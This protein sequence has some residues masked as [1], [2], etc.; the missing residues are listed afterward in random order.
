MKGGLA[1]LNYTQDDWIR[2][3]S[4][5]VLWAK[6]GLEHL[7]NITEPFEQ[8]G[9]KIGLTLITVSNERLL[10]EINPEHPYQLITQITSLRSEVWQFR[11]HLAYLDMKYKETLSRKGSNKY[12]SYKEDKRTPTS[13]NPVNP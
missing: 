12:I 8:I 7:K 4:Q 3:A 2:V 11:N 1:C 10:Q 9:D 6:D 5:N 13:V